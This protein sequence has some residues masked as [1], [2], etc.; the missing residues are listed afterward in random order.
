MPENSWK[1]YFAFSKR[2]RNNVFILLGII[3]MFIILPFWLRPVLSPP[4]I[5]KALQQKLAAVTTKE[6]FAA[7]A[8]SLDEENADSIRETHTTHTAGVIKTGKELFYFDP[9]TATNIELRRLGFGEKT[10]EHIIEYRQASRFKTPEDLYNVPRIRKKAVERV[11]A[12]I[13]IGSASKQT[14]QPAPAKATASPA[15]IPAATQSPGHYTVVVVNTA[16]AADFKQF[17]GVTD[18]VANRVIKFRNSVN[19]FT[20]IDDVAKTYGLPDSSFKFMRPYLRLQ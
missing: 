20:S 17:P 7:G 14:T 11:L 1:E 12:Y 19:G 10:A 9:N 5:D 16:T 4:V 13:K 8:D 6:H 15:S 18:A 3:A 2:Q